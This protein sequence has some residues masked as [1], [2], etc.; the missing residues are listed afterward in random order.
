MKTAFQN[1]IADIVA[2]A[3][4]LNHCKVDGNQ[5]AFAEALM[6]A[7]ITGTVDNVPKADFYWQ[8]MCLGN[9][10]T[11]IEPTQEQIARVK[12]TSDLPQVLGIALDSS[13]VPR[14]ALLY[15]LVQALLGDLVE[16]N[17]TTGA[18]V[19]GKQGRASQAHRVEMKDVRTNDH[20]AGKLVRFFQGAEPTDLISGRVR[21]RSQPLV[22][23]LGEAFGL[24]L[25]QLI[26][27]LQMEYPTATMAK[28]L[29]PVVQRGLLGQEVVIAGAFCPDYSYVATGNP[30]LPYCYTFTSVGSGVGLVAQQFARVTPEI[31]AFLTK[32]GIKHRIVLGIGDFEANSQE[33]LD[34]VKLTKNEFHDRCRA[35]LV[36]FKELVGS[37]PVELEMYEIDR[38]HDRLRMYQL[39]AQAR[40]L[41]GDFGWMNQVYNEPSQLVSQIAEE[42]ATFYRRWYGDSLTAEEIR[43]KV[44][45]QGSEYAAMARIDREDFGENLLILS[46]D[47]PKMHAF[48][49][50]FGNTPVLAVKRAY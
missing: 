11:K 31:S 8:R 37:L 23:T 28:L 30:T 19:G 12:K 40:M 3:S 35:S 29:A 33:T 34:G 14:G 20:P 22:Q 13:D 21:S 44:I 5:A 18:H 43:R 17:F 15:E 47:R 50:L 1:V 36:A 10:P 48:D 39:E 38:G 42:S 41:A 16:I 45:G 27:K 32:H 46:G 2:L 6:T 7:D 49:Q 25:G 24:E 9:E 26:Q 4:Y